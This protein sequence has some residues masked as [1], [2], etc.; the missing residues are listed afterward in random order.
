MVKVNSFVLSDETYEKR[1]RRQRKFKSHWGEYFAISCHLFELREKLTI[2]IF[3]LEVL[4]LV[5]AFSNNF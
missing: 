1:L 2:K 5:K 4:N 3:H